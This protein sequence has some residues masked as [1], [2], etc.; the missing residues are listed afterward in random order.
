MKVSDSEIKLLN[1]IWENEPVKS[2]E[3]VNAA[4]QEYGWRKSTVY[5]ILKK[6]CEKGA[7]KNHE[8]I[9]TSLISREELMSEN[10]GKV[11]EDKFGGSI[12]MFLTAF[13]SREKLSEEKAMELKRLIDEHTGK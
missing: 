1:L 9:T 2:G 6:L 7:A 4:F 13:L 11:I 5:T 8:S 12:S 3:L 10:S